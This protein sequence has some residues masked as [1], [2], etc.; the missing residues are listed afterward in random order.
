MSRLL[1]KR[2]LDIELALVG[3]LCLSPVL[4]LIA[5]LVLRGMG[6]PVFFVQTRPGRHETPFR[7][8]KFRTMTQAT[9]PDGRL[10]P[11]SARLTR[12]GRFLRSSSLDELPELW[13]VLRGDMSL[14]G[15]R[16]LLNEYLVAYDQ[17]ER[18]RHDVRPGITGLAQVRGRN[19]V[20]W[21][22]KMASDVEYVQRW[23]LTLDAAIMARTFLTVLSRRDVAVEGGTQ[24]PPA[25]V[26]RNDEVEA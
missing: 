21:S 19:S 15:P 25:K 17:R 11:N 1:L 2:V 6:R 4:A 3:L 18:K 8:V 9:G 7:L 5:V 13:N 20:R 23:S 16:P 24:R 14:V 10:L 22:D 12:F 26:P